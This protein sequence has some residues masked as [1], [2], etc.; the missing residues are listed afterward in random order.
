MENENRF[1]LSDHDSTIIW[2]GYNAETR[3]NRFQNS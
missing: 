1:E 2:K 3:M